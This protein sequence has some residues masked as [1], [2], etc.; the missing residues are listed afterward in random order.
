MALNTRLASHHRTANIVAR[1]DTVAISHHGTLSRFFPVSPPVRTEEHARTRVC[2]TRRRRSLHSHTLSRATHSTEI[3]PACH[4]RAEGDQRPAPK[5]L[6][7][8]TG[9]IARA[10]SFLREPERRDMRAA[11]RSV[12]A[13]WPSATQ[14]SLFAPRFEYSNVAPATECSLGDFSRSLELHFALYNNRLHRKHWMI[15]LDAHVVSFAS[16][17]P[18]SAITLFFSYAQDA[19]NLETYLDHGE[20]YDNV[21]TFR[22]KGPILDEKHVV[23]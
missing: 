22:R 18:T 16:V 12:H 20:R 2:S 8:T 7:A 15:E 21:T 14:L 11:L 13:H 10:D 5:R 23:V 4:D 3:T 6:P 1:H 17:I 9:G 19:Y